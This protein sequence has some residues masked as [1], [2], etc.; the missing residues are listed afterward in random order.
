MMTFRFARL[1]F[2]TLW[3]AIPTIAIA[4]PVAIAPP[5]DINFSNNNEVLSFINDISQKDGFKPDMLKNLFSQAKYKQKIIDAITRPAESKPWYEYRPIFLNK[6]RIDEGVAFWNKNQQVLEQAEKE[7]G[8]PPEVIVAI[9]GVETRYGKHKG[10]FRV[11]DA[12][13]TLAFGFPQRADFFRSE[14]EQYLLL[15][16]E[17]KLD[18]LAVKGS[19]AGA[20]GNAQFISSSYR[21]Y[22]VD[23]D[24]DGKRDLWN[25]ISDTIGSVANYFKRHQWQPGGEITIPVTVE[26]NHIQEIVDKGIKPHSTVAELRMSGITPKSPLNPDEMGA[27][28]ELEDQ[29]GKEYWLGFNNFYVI[30]RYNHSPLYA[31]AVYQLGQAILNNRESANKIANKHG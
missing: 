12:L 24:G 26:G 21:S 17:E 9:L 1:S 22:A 18:P 2:I 20:M 19:Y 28:I 16:R 31:M 4:A 23:F 7:Y 11:M 27:L 13:S 29:T 3:L 5:F 30:T 15:T 6:K 25:N 14:L 10:T 8:V